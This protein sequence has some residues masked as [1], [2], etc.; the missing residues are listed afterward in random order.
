MKLLNKNLRSLLLLVF[1]PGVFLGI[2]LHTV[3]QSED[4]PWLPPVNLSKSGSVTELAMTVDISGTYHLLWQD[5]FV[6]FEYLSG[7]GE[8]WSEPAI[9]R[10]PFSEPTFS[11]PDDDDFD[12]LFT[13]ILVADVNN[14]VHAFWE[15]GDTVLWYSRAPLAEV[16]TRASWTTRA[17]LSSAAIAQDV[18]VDDNG[19]LHLTYIRPKT[20]AETE[21]G[22]YYRYSDDGGASWTDPVLL[23]QS[24]Y[25]HLDATDQARVKIA[26]SPEIGLFVV[27]DNRLIDRVFV[28]HLNEDGESWAE[29]LEVDRRGPESDGLDTAGPS[30]I[31][32]AMVG[33]EVHLTWQAS[34]ESERCVQFH[35][36]SDDQGQTWQSRQ[37]AYG[38]SICPTDA[39]FIVR[40]TVLFLLI[41]VDDQAK[42]MVWDSTQWSE[43]TLQPLVE[44]ADPETYH[45]LTLDCL[46]FDV[47]SDNQL[48][49]IGCGADT[50]SDD[51]WL[52]QRPLGG[53]EEW[54]ALFNPIPVWNEPSLIVQSDTQLHWPQLVTA[55]D[56]RMHAVWS[57][58]DTP[59]T[60]NVFSDSSIV[61]Q[62]INYTQSNSG[63]WLPPRTVIESSQNTDQP[64][65]AAGNDGSLYLVWSGGDLGE[66]FVRRV[67]ANRAA[68][69]SEWFDS[70]LL[71]VPKVGGS[72]PDVAT[73]GD[74]TVFVV[75]SVPLNEARG[76]YLTHS[77]DGGAT[78]SEPEQIFDGAAAEWEM[79][80]KPTIAASSE[81]TLHLL[82]TQKT[83]A[84]NGQSVALVHASSQDRGQSWTEP[85]I[86]TED[87]VIW[88]EM[89][90]LSDLNLHRAWV[91]QT[92]NL[93][94]L[95]HQQSLDGGL[96]WSEPLRLSDPSVRVGPV[97]LI[98]DPA[99]EP[100]LLLLEKSSLEDTITLK[101]WLW[102]DS[103]WLQEEGMPLQKEAIDAD[104]IAAALL[105]DETLTV[106][107][108]S[109][110]TQLVDDQL[111]DKLLFT[112]RQWELPSVTATPLPTLT[113]T[114][115]ATPTATPTPPPSPTPTLAIPTTQEDSQT[116]Q[117]GPLDTG[118]LTGRLL[119][120]I[121]PAV[122][123]VAIAFAIGLRFRRQR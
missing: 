22:V 115:Q 33:D 91:S 100:H 103:R 37:T 15:D 122:L 5:E 9:V 113:P 65:I 1:L 31:D 30:Q 121:I 106:I 67:F 66:V 32:I 39:Q 12:S 4:G 104:G 102:R 92:D 49:V 26:I 120:G 18:I 105:P 28:T 86:V 10:L 64:A 47:T 87:T 6:G 34:H 79:V 35:T 45:N 108:S 25:F 53:L 109:L 17:R 54:T 8:N 14:I 97:T 24:D 52:L 11:S 43:P 60:G 77:E 68:S 23:Y 123:I 20:T 56:G 99:G 110:V 76:L 40:D 63:S 27:W 93:T 78:W 90:T 107:Y 83:V 80:G 118:S 70:Q 75:Y 44:F 2:V 85:Q 61:D 55:V 82:W 114:P 101:H 59:V 57:Q 21:A 7:S 62:R 89:I 42:L 51:I 95:W 73:A 71:S 69:V 116:L 84:Q 88:S 81:N 58:S 19:R 98:T 117:I 111:Y 72:W 3:A 13:P 112:Q 29:P 119:L 74:K 16:T 48:V 94:A 46:N 36:W 50:L 41:R 38:D 96:T